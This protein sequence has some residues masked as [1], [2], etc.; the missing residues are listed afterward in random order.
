MR[1]L[2]VLV[3]VM[4]VLLVAVAVVNERLA[5]PRQGR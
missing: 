2:K 3:V 4:G 1:A 5:N